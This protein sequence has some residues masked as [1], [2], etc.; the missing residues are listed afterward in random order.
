MRK[1]IAPII[2]GVALVLGAP[3]LA[4]SGC[5]GVK[6]QT[7]EADGPIATPVDTASTVKSDTSG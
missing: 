4:G 2:V 7:V 5:G 6:T 1:F 3:A